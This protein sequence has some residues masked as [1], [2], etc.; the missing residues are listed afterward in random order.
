MYSGKQAQWWEEGRRISVV[1][2]AMEMGIHVNQ[3]L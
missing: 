2:G 3:L 1:G